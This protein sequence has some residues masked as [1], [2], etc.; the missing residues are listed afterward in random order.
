MPERPGQPT[1]PVAATA[2]P[3]LLDDDSE[4]ISAEDSPQYDF[5]TVL[6]EMEVVV[7]Q[8]ELSDQAEP[9]AAAPEDDAVEQFI[10]Q[11]GSFRSAA[12]ADEMKARL[13]LL[14]SV[15][16]IQQVTV[17]N[18]TWHR[19]RIGPVSGAR[20]ADSLRRQLQDNGIEVLVLNQKRRS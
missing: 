6:P 7:P 1:E 3:G 2:E 12:D 9:G 14:G 5:F 16:T 4:V 17:D 8:R 13:A 18:Q 20:A 19:V 15:A 11:A 10:L